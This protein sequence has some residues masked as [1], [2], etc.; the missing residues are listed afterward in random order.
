MGKCINCGTDSALVAQFLGVCRECILKDFHSVES[1]IQK[2]HQVS[3]EPFNL[4]SSP[5]RD[6]KGVTC[7]YCFNQLLV[8]GYVDKEEVFQIAEFVAGLE[9]NIPYVL[10]GFHPH[11]YFRDMP[12]TSRRHAEECRQAAHEAG[13]QNVRVGNIHLLGRDY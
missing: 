8:P 12:V 2:A 9:P 13:L 7:Q 4:P 5:P 10:L 3:R 1:H 6:R 11:F